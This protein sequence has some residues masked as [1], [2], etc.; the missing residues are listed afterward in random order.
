M[1]IEILKELANAHIST[2]FDAFGFE[3]YDKYEYL[4]MCCP[5]HGGDNPTAFSW[6][7]DGGYFRCFTRKCERGGADIFDFVQK[8]KK[9]SFEDAKSIV[10]SICITGEYKDASEDNIEAEVEFR[11]YIKDNK[12]KDKSFTFIDPKVLS[13]LKPHP[14]LL[15]RGFSKQTLDK[16]RV[17]YCANPDSLYY[18]RVCVPVVH[19][20]GGIVA[21][22]AR[23][24]HED[25]KERKVGKW[26]HTPH[27]PMGQILFNL[28]NAKK[29]IKQS[30]TA[31]LVEGP[32]DVFKL[33][34][35]GIHNSVAILGSDLSGVQRSLLLKYECWD[36]VLGFDGDTAGKDCANKIKEACKKYFNICSFEVPEGKDIGDLSV[37]EIQNLHVIKI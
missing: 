28:N 35:A 25:Y 12:K 3:Y 18:E 37:E 5:I 9:C 20:D 22:T 14:Y 21:F 11:K 34:M 19:H 29:H 7:K 15:E 30:H 6:V 23:T 32:L 4:H 16:Y 26:I 2:I 17:G 13:D 10:E 36:I 8:Y 24:V 31:V 27:A 33:E 1:K